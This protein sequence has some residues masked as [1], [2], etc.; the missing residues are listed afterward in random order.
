MIFR[1]LHEPRSDVLSYLIA[2]P[3]TSKA[4]IIDG[5]LGQASVYLKAMK[6]LGLVLEYLLETH[7][8]EDHKSVSPQLKQVTPARL[9]VHEQ[10]EVRC[11]DL[12]LRDGDV[13]YLGEEAVEVIHTPGHSP[14][15]VTY[16]WRE[17]L[18]TGHTL[19]VGSVGSCTEPGADAGQLYDSVHQRL[20]S[21]PGEYL[22]YPGR[23]T[24]GHRVSSIEQER[25]VNE[26]LSFDITRDQ[27]IALRS[28]RGVPAGV[29]APHFARINQACQE[30]IP[31]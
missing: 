31:A 13:L 15:S 10:G 6:Q 19:L 12:H 5:V 29:E 14:C 17:R 20:Y 11:A 16:R 4:A 26:A 3:V 25:R 1:Q 2:D 9:A 27:F 8:H 22:V 7:V 28:G 30:V 21:K 18:F 23:A 24:D